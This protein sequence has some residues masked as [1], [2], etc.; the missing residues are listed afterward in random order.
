MKKE[1][2]DVSSYKSRCLTGELIKKSGLILV[3]ASNHMD[4]IIKRAPDAAGKVHLL[5]QYGL[6][7]DEETCEDL[8]I[9]DPIGK[10]MSYYKQVLDTIKKET[11]RIAHVIARSDSDE[12]I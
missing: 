10:P 6:K 7:T 5:K 11:K 4:D 3:M 1:G 9:L 2:V 12:A 8:D